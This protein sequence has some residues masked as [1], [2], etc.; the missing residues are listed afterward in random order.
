[1]EIS[2]TISVAKNQA[3]QRPYKSRQE[4]RLAERRKADDSTDNAFLIK[5]AVLIGFLILVVVGFVV[6]GMSNH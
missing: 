2:R 6:K 1:M 3:Y 5:V 4:R